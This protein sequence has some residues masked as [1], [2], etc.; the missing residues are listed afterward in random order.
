MCIVSTAAN[1]T[2]FGFKTEIEVRVEESDNL[3]D[4][5]HGLGTDAIA[6]QE[7]KFSGC[8]NAKPLFFRAHPRKEGTGF[9]ENDARQTNDN[10]G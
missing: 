6:G 8:H 5:R 9:S 1:Q 2:F 10:G 4:L 7:K 3:A